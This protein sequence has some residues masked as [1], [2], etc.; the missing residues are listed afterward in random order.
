MMSV[1]IVGAGLAG[2]EAALYLAKQGI[3]VNLYE[4]KTIHRSAAH[5]TDLPAELVC[6]NSFG[7][8]RENSA[9]G[10][11]K[12]EITLLGG[13]LFDIAHSV[14][15]PAG[16]A[17]AVQRDDFS[18][19]VNSALQQ[20]PNILLIRERVDN[21]EDIA[22]SGL[23]MVATGPMTD[24]A[25]ADSLFELIGGNLSYYDAAAPIVTADSLDKQHCF[26]ASRY[27]RGTDD[28]INCPM[29][30]E[31]YYDFVQA[32]L[33]AERALVHD[34]DKVYEGC[35]PV[36]VLASRG[37]DSLRF[38]PLKPVGLIDPSTDKR[39]FANLQLRKEDTGGRLL[40]LVGFQTNLKFGE[41][42]RVFGMIPALSG[43]EYVRYGVMHRNSFINS[44]QVLNADLS[45]KSHP[46]IILCGGITGFEGY[47]ESVACGLLAARFVHARLNGKPITHP[48]FETMCGGLLRHILTESKDFQPQGAA[49]GLLPPLPERIKD[50]QLRYSAV[51]NRALEALRL[52]INAGAE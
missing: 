48:P 39:P 27:G 37:V 44:P 20:Q 26:S 45:L 31:Q 24:G 29:T 3:K 49:M 50:K 38:G 7:A 25:F 10:L 30:R 35:M 8:F 2:C 13:S 46:D 40:N 34:F 19:A 51:A 4:Q 42:R 11:L 23:T 33:D 52:Y 22:N 9:S 41:Q 1:N 36:E 32:L 6:S 43:A 5:S 17:L 18:A 12:K 15:V 28:Y 47:S 21:I 16:G 14:S